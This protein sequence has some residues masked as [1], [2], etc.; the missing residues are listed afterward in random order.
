MLPVRRIRFRSIQTMAM[1]TK[2][3]KALI[4]P[5]STAV[6]HESDQGNTAIII[7]AIMIKDMP[8]T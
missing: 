7:N 5:L 6:N 1:P 8:T 3:K 4:L 2:I